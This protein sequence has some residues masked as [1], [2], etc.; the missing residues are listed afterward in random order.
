MN[1]LNWSKNL[2][3]AF[4]IQDQLIFSTVNKQDYEIFAINIGASSATILKYKIK[5]RSQ[6]ITVAE[7]LNINL[8]TG[9]LNNI[10]TSYSFHR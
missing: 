1:A 6:F 3:I 10:K 9:L 7:I 4:Y 8:L 2:S 5:K